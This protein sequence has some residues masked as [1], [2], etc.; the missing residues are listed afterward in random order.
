MVAYKRI[1]SPRNP[2]KGIYTVPSLRRR[3]SASLRQKPGQYPEV[4]LEQLQQGKLAAEL[5]DV[6]DGDALS[7]YHG[8][9]CPYGREMYLRTSHGWIQGLKGLNIVFFRL[10]CTRLR[11]TYM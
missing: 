4:N 1:K 10:C 8:A 11:L 7:M 6:G 2:N 5:V 3:A 9:D